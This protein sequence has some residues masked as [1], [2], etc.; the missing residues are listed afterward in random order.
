MVGWL[1]GGWGCVVHLLCPEELLGNS[2]ATD[3]G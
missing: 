3:A 1:I 2:L